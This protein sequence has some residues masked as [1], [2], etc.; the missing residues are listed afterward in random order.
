MLHASSRVKK[1]KF[2]VCTAAAIVAA[3]NLMARAAS[4]EVISLSGL[5][6][7]SN[8]VESVDPL[9]STNINAALLPGQSNLNA[10]AADP[11][12]TYH[13]PTESSGALSSAPAGSVTN[14]IVTHATA[15]V[16]TAATLT[17]AAVQPAVTTAGSLGDGTLA[18]VYSPTTGDVTIKYNGDTRITA[19]ALLQI[20]A[21]LANTGNPTLV[22]GALQ[23][24]AFSNSTYNTTTLRGSQ[25][26]ASIPDAY[27]LGNILPAGLDQATLLSGLLLQYYTK[28]GLSPKVAEL[29]YN[30][31]PEPT[32]LSLIGVGAAGLLARRRKAKKA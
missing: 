15:A 13:S 28:G 26:T 1:L 31:V 16:V 20:T 14:A 9:V 22:S 30:G 17:S 23:S 18:Y 5:A 25:T 27:D 11:G 8:P 12:L 10:T 4:P 29:I 32:T 6:S 19:T 7:E 2:Q 21:I 3:T 24:G